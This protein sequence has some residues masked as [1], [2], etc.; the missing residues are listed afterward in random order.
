MAT[1]ES[2]KV[3]LRQKAT[4]ATPKQPLSDTQ[5]RDGFNILV[6]GS[7]W[8]TYEEFIIPELSRG[9][10]F[11]GQARVSVLEVGP[12][13]KSILGRLPLCKRRKIFRYT[14]FE[15]N[16]LF[17]SQLGEWLSPTVN[18]SDTKP[19][20]PR[21][22]DTPDIRPVP[23]TLETPIG[24]ED[25]RGFDLVLLCHSMY[26]LKPQ[27]QY[28]ERALEYLNK[29]GWLVVFHREG[30][31]Q[32]NG[33]VC[34]AVASFPTGI[35][36]VAD[37]DE[38]L[39]RFT[40]FVAGFDVDEAT[41]AEWR[42]VSRALGSH[43]EKTPGY[44]TFSAPE[45]MMVMNQNATIALPTLAAQVPIVEAGR[46][47]KSWE[48]R[49]CHPAAIAR[50]T[51]IRQI[52]HCVRWAMKYGV[53]LTVMGGSHSA[54]CLRPNVVAVDMS[55]FR[56]VH[57]VAPA[58]DDKRPG[59]TPEP[60]SLV[61]VEAGCTT[62]TVIRQTMEAGLTV[63]LGSRPSVGAGLWLQGGIGHLARL[64]GLTCDAI[65]GAV[66]VDVH[67]G[68][69]VCV[70]NVPSQ[71]RPS[72]SVRAGDWEMDILWAIPGA[73][74]NFGIV[75]SVVFRAQPAPV[76]TVRNWV[77]PLKHGSEAQS[78]LGHLGERAGNLPRHCSADLYLY[79]ENDQ[80]NLGVTRIDVSTAEHILQADAP[81]FAD[82]GP[83]QDVQTV[84]GVGLFGTEM[85]MSGMN[86]G[87]GGGKTTSFKRCMFLKDIGAEPV[88]NILTASIETCPSPLCY[89]HLLQGGGK[90]GDVDAKSTAFGCRDWSYACV[91]TGVWPRDQDGTEV[92]RRVVG[93][94]YSV[95]NELLPFSSGVYVADLGPDPRDS[96]LATRAFGPNRWRL[97]RLKDDL[98]PHH[99]LAYACPLPSVRAR[100]KDVILVTGDSGSGKDYCAEVWTSILNERGMPARAVSI[101]DATKREYAS[102]TG[103]SLD[104]LLGDRLYKEQHREALGAFFQSQVQQNPDLP[105][106]HFLDMLH[107]NKRAAVLFITG[108]RDE[109][110][111]TTLAHLRPDCRLLDIRIQASEETRRLRKGLHKCD[112]DHAGGDDA[113]NPT[114]NNEQP[115]T[116]VSGYRPTLV[117]DNNL[118]GREAAE[119]FA[120]ERL[121]TLLHEEDLSR[122]YQM[123]RLVPH[124]PRPGIGFR[125]VLNIAQQPG[126]LALCTNHLRNQFYGDWANVDAV[127][128]CEAGG[129][130][131]ASALAARVNVPL[132]LIREAGKLAPPTVSAEKSQSYISSAAASSSG[133]SAGPAASGEGKRI[134]MDHDVVRPGASVVVVDDVLAT[135][136]TLCT[137][138]QLLKEAGVGAENVSILVVAEFPVH[139]GRELLKKRGY[140]SA[141]VHSLLVFD[142]A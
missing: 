112:A 4:V 5:Y 103:A 123:V 97:A 119:R 27:H 52:Q 57:I 70:G 8:R 137:V 64:Y 56:K 51:E 93:W 83:E 79:R 74:T 139:R 68:Q 82:L 87:H 32:P 88:A 140:G 141:H 14:A 71:H 35:I 126:G 50:P 15:S 60:G 21:L 127:A 53:G 96:P 44:L 99:V 75:V 98:D 7:G 37:D 39:D 135:G 11:N 129:F 26:G 124:F 28:L 67:S 89:L 132:A 55:A 16:R 19:P 94:V 29:G 49:A 114:T 61:V 24:A 77:L 22:G 117:F 90:V 58:E 122:L 18:T 3:A 115:N 104:R 102:A 31:L 107:D 120:E 65:L 13:P 133:G 78:R 59:P 12:G 106:D 108:M 42:E 134:E 48:A 113:R 101:S 131:F 105:E 92:A 1:L 73:G 45:V 121:L 20:M 33:L 63:P 125:H 85:Y 10:L 69:L 100:P 66:M 17:A 2:L 91:V 9:P 62:D 54:H 110:P 6:Q 46:T 111:V 136:K 41:Q 80:L 25:H 47:I 30:A 76:Y 84:D 130:I 34:H 86:G 38:P 40:R 142:G 43:E 36:S 23:F 81:G 109:A 118:T 128:C 138:L 72:D 116:G 95:V